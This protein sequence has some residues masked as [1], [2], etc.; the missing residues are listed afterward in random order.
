MALMEAEIQRYVGAGIRR[1]KANRK[2]RLAE[3]FD[4][5]SDELARLHGP[6]GLAID[7]RPR[8]KLRCQW[9]HRWLP[10]NARAMAQ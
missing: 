9:W 5:T 6:I 1:N 4:V 7:A 3:H 8:P 2:Q 10:K